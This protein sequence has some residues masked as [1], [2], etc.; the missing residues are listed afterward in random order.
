MNRAVAAAVAALLLL[1]A[2]GCRQ[3][4]HDGPYYERYE[5]SA[6]FEDGRASRP[7]ALT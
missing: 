3:D 7:M 5:R 4:M 6:F 1:G 2:A